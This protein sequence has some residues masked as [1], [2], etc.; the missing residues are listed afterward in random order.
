MRVSAE[1]QITVKANQETC[2]GYAT[3]VRAAPDIF[4]LGEE[5]V[6]T[7]LQEVVPGDRLDV[8]RRAE[9]D[10]PTDSISFVQGAEA[11]DSQ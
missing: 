3:C 4:D 7:L 1:P 2:E 5:G 8:V 9:Y 11:H 6:V 10:C